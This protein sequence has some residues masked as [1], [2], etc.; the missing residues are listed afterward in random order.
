[1]HL[2]YVANSVNHGGAFK[3]CKN[4]A[5]NIR[6]FEPSIKIDLVITQY[7]DQAELTSDEFDSTVVITESIRLG[8]LIASGRY[9]LIHWWKSNTDHSFSDVFDS[10][11]WRPPLLVTLCQVPSRAKY[12]LSIANYKHAD[13]VVF[14]C[15]A[16]RKHW[17]IRLFPFADSEMIY[18]G[19]FAKFKY[20]SDTPKKKS[21]S[22]IFGR[23][24]ALGKC[25][26]WAID[27]FAK[28]DSPN[29][30]F[31]IYG[32]GSNNIKNALES[33]VK[34]FSLSDKIKLKDQLSED[35]WIKAVSRLDIF[36]Y[37]LHKDGFSAIDVTIQDAMLMRVPVVYY[38]PF[39]PAELIEH[40]VT[41]YVANNFQEFIQYAQLLASDEKK[42]NIMGR[43]ANRRI[44]EKFS[45][46]TTIQNYIK[47]YT[48]MIEERRINR[49][50]IIPRT[51]PVSFFVLRACD[52]AFDILSIIKKKCI[53]HFN[54][55]FNTIKKY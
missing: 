9:A 8:E 29:S 12:G 5:K 50:T 16:A 3:A 27:A 54:N 43:M 10:L 48:L 52:C 13:K 4:L 32:S 30:E 42:R 38:G 33:R 46:E 40:G 44:K 36:F 25:P 19:T 35:D 14:V 53:Y 11:S 20:N 39:G 47:L 41:G 28:L 51:I 6:S 18:F 7:S 2:L 24:S 1:M 45:Y 31:L 55:A 34:K 49:Q 26:L 15:E 37:A 17:R 23:G 22:I 21:N